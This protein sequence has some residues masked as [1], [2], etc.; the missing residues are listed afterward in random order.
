[1]RS[2]SFLRDNAAWLSA[3]FLLTL[4]SSFGQT[5]FISLFA[6][7]IRETFALSNGQW[8]G[9]YTLAT[10]ASALVMVWT[11]ALTDRYRGERQGCFAFFSGR[12]GNRRIHRD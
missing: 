10:T 1:M 4:S 3:G 8:G 12:F 7:Q 11:G 5:F 6:G 9:L 2:G